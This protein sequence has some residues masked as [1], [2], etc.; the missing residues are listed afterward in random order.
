MSDESDRRKERAHGGVVSR[1][2]N[3][4][5]LGDGSRWWIVGEPWARN[6]VDESIAVDRV[7]RVQRAQSTAWQ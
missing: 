4:A 2:G 6:A 1:E 7:T 3:I 5:N